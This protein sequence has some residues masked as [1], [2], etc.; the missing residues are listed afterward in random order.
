[1]CARQPVLIIRRGDPLGRPPQH[2]AS[3]TGTNLVF[4]RLS[5]KATTGSR[6]VWNKK[7]VARIRATQRVGHNERT[8]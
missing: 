6:E 5:G 4:A 1:M 8:H 7:V 3:M 2:T